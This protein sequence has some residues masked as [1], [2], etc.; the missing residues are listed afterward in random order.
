[1]IKEFER[2]HGAV[3]RQIVVD[4]GASGVLIRAEDCHG[5]L[6]SFVLNDRIG[7]FIKHSS[8]RLPPW[9]FTFGDENTLELEVLRSQTSTLWVVL[10]CGG[11]GFVAIN[12]REFLSMN[13]QDS[14]ATAFV[15]IDRDR[16]SMYRLNGSTGLL[17]RPKPRGFRRILEQLHKD[18]NHG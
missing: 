14:I 18:G 16:R 3:I 7:L 17:P 1:M 10:V 8:K 12:H 11:D 6:N 9:Q 2:Y 4:A 15:R 13:S 5:R